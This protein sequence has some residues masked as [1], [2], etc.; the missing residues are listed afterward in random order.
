MA[1]GKA[2]VVFDMDGTLTRKYLDFDAIRR[3]IGIDH[4]PILEAMAEM[5]PT[6]RDAAHRIIDRHERD[7]AENATLHDNAK[8][9]LEAL[10]AASFALA[11]ITR[12]SRR[13]AEHVLNKFGMQFDT[14]RTR[15][16]GPVKPSPEQLLSI[17]AELAVRPRDAWMVG[18]HKFDLECGQNAGAKTILMVGD[19]ELPDYAHLADH[20]VRDLAEI[21]A[22]VAP[23]TCDRRHR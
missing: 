23:Q 14:T 5:T 16:D 6:K 10:R 19:D 18:D 4:R 1:S 2:A 12:N 3:E 17:C 21:P 11:L 8:E 15:E 7:A 13:S 22:L 20:V 9:T